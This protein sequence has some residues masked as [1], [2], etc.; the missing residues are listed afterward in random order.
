MQR[1][2]LLLASMVAALLLASGVGL[3]NAVKPAEATFP[4]KNGKIAFAS[5]SDIGHNIHAIDADGTGEV[6]LTNDRGGN[7]WPAWS[8]DGTKLAF[9][10]QSSLYTMN[11]D[12]TGQTEIVRSL[13][14]PEGSPSMS[15]I[16]SP[17]WSPDGT[18]IAFH[19][20]SAYFYGTP[21]FEIYVVNSDGTNPTK[22]TNN[23][24]GDFFPA[25]SPNGSKIAF[26]STRDS[27]NFGP[28][29]IHYNSNQEIFVMDTDGAN[30][31]RLTQHNNAE[32]CPARDD[33][34]SAFN[35]QPDW[36]PDGSKIA[37]ISIRTG[38]PTIFTMNADGSGQTELAQSMRLSP[39]YPVWSPDGSKIAFAADIGGAIWTI[40]AQGATAPVQVTHDNKEGIFPDWQAIRNTTPPPP[41]PTPDTTPPKVMSTV[42]GAGATRVAPT[43]NVKATFSEDMMASTINKTTFTLRKQG[44]TG[45]VAATVTYDPSTKTAT[46][47]PTNSL[48]RGATYKASVNLGAQDQAG[49]PLDQSASLSGSQRKDWTF[50][51]RS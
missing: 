5:F 40:D 10:R 19:A 16:G 43:V 29:P 46:L 49:N 35:G 24:G 11:A 18:K 4:G 38:S 17:T 37:F 15:E 3:L 8:A 32:Y 34:R 12:G 13:R 6:V 28:E 51:V 48:K 31:V 33:C 14:A 47:D 20:N 44:S 22:I 45:F 23:P 36:S 27:V 41:P 2:V 26:T 21:N 25:W 30:P 7:N 42:P 1:I 9:L 39:E 50:K